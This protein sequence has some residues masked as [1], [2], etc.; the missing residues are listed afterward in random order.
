MLAGASGWAVNDS[1]VAP[2]SVG[3]SAEIRTGKLAEASTT[4][5]IESSGDESFRLQQIAVDQ[6]LRQPLRP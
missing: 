5:E 6:P 1:F 3:I 4:N 2:T